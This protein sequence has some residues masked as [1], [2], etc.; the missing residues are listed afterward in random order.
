MRVFV[1]GQDGTTLM[2]CK[3]QKA[4]KLIETKK[5]TVYQKNPYTIKLCYQT[6]TATQPLTIGV[7]TGSQNIG[8]AV[9]SNKE[10]LYKAESNFAVPWESGSCWKHVDSTVVVED[11]VRLDFVSQSSRLLQNV[12]TLK[13]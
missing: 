13:S 11:T 2:P 8:V 10:A 9:I 6:G 3:Q 5:A 4:R 7:D 1:I 12:C